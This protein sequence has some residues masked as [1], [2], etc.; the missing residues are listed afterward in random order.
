MNSRTP[1]A[2]T[3]NLTV[4]SFGL[5]FGSPGNDFGIKIVARDR[6]FLIRFWSVI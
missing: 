1:M 4:V 5:A 2:H 3:Q 6:R